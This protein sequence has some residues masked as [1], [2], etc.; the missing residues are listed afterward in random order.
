MDWILIES[1]QNNAVK[2]AASL[3]DKKARDREGLFVAEGS[4]LFFDFALRGLFPERVYLS[5]RAEK[6]KEEIERVL[7]SNPCTLYLLSSGAFEKVTTEKGSEGIVSLYSLEKLRKQIPLERTK[8]LIALENVQDPGNVGTVIRSAASFGADG[9]LLT[10]CAD[11][12]GPKAVRASMGAVAHVPVLTFDGID[13]MMDTLH[14]WRVRSVAACLADDA[15]KIGET[16]LSSP[17]CILIGN[18][19][20]GLSERAV[21]RSCEKSIIPIQKTESLN[22]AVAASVFLWEMARRDEA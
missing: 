3:A 7:Q 5:E 16:S 14:E 21:A 17:V 4:T 12:F 22:A 2:L 19:G 6:R 8:R 11:P 18:E 10:G 9:V 1:R 15:K 20:K 13:Q